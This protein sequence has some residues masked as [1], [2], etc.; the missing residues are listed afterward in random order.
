MLKNNIVNII[1]DGILIRLKIK[2]NKTCQLNNRNQICKR[3]NQIFEFSEIYALATWPTFDAAK[4]LIWY[5][6]R[7]KGIRSKGIN[8]CEL[9]VRSVPMTCENFSTKSGS[10]PA[11]FSFFM[12]VTAD[13][14]WL[15]I[16]KKE[17]KEKIS[18]EIRSPSAKTRWGEV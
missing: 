11:A 16:L 17:K 9:S 13:V 10:F 3:W 4:K 6:I 15:L 14:M 5:S 18:L 7:P 1:L 12:E 2:A 8:D